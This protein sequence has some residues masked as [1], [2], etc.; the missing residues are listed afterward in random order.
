MIARDGGKQAE[1]CGIGRPHN[2]RPSPSWLWGCVTHWRVNTYDNLRG[3][4]HECGIGML[5]IPQ[6]ISK[7]LW[8]LLTTLESKHLRQRAQ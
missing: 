6:I 5:P 4:G 1:F 3:D 7:Q 8:G 2:P